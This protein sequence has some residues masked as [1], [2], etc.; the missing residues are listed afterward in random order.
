MGNAS[1][2]Q[3]GLVNFAGILFLIAGAFNAI[4]G[5]V[6]IFN[7]DYL[8]NETLF[9]D[10]QVWAWFVL[11]TGI[12]QFLVGIGILARS[13]GGRIVG[14]LIATFGAFLQLTFILSFPA[15]SIIIIVLDLVI[16]YALTV[17]GDE[18]TF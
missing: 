13:P 6:G 9:A 4:Y 2:R 11:A 8:N 10:I 15:W 16:I 1:L 3:S 14:L 5:L 17:H 12:V 18:F 7:E